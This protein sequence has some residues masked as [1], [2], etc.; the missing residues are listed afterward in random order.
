M[1]ELTRRR[2]IALGLRARVPVITRLVAFALLV[3]GIAVVGI[4]YYKLRNAEKFKAKSEQPELSK[5]VTGVIEGY[6]QRVTKN[7]RLYL[8]V[9]ASRDVTFSDSHH[10]LE[11]V[12]MAVYPPEG[13]TPDQISAA[14][15]IFHPDSNVLAFMGNVKIETK[16]KL[17]VN[18]D[19]LSFDQNSGIAQTDSPVTFERENVS[20]TSTGAMVEQ[21]AKKL[22]LKN[23]VALTIAPGHATKAAARAR[24]VS[25]K[26][27]HGT[28]DQQSMQLVFGGGVTVEQEA[29]IL[30]GDTLNAFINEQ[31]R[32]QRAEL[33][34]NSY[35]R[36]MDPG[37]AAEVHSVNMDFFMDQDQRL[38]RALATNDIAARTL[39]GDADVQVSGSN[40]L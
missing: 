9:K 25:I 32:L 28:F 36:V 39:E 3:S 18:T 34:G 4:S 11:N 22:T 1:Q 29:D 5:E 23:N 6:E 31:K 37:R 8:L 14:R 33:R 35:M 10:E 16:E 30:S 17:K 40:S 24:P 26:A 38:Q 13:E 20:G 21:K 2:A 15:A 19:A 27:A 7:D 12:N